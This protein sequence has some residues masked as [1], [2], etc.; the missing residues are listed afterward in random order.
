MPTSVYRT[1][2]Q[3]LTQMIQDVQASGSLITDFNIGSVARVLLEAEAAG[4]SY[5]S[6]VA[7]QL[8]I[9][10]YLDTA[11]GAALD[12]LAGNFQVTRLPSMLATGEVTI[13]RSQSSYGL[14]IPAGWATLS[15]IPE[16]S[17]ESVDVVTL[18]DAVFAPGQV[19]VSV[20]AQALA[21]GRSGNL[22]GGQPLLPTVPVQGVSSTGG[23]ATKDQWAGGVDAETDDALRYRIP[24][25][26][27]GRVKGTRVSVLG[28]VLS[29]PGVIGANV[30]QAGDTRGD[31]TTIPAGTFEVYYRG[32]DGLLS[33]VQSATENASVLNQN[34]DAFAS[35]DLGGPIMLSAT[36]DALGAGLTFPQRG[37]MRTIVALTVYVNPGTDYAIT[38]GDVFNAIMGYVNV[39]TVGERALLSRVINLLHQIPAVISV[40]LPVTDF[41]LSTDLVGTAADVVPLSDSYVNLVAS[42]LSIA[43]STLS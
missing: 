11:T 9:D 5:Q 36:F 1:V 22:A 34:G 4:L 16:P 18:D 19:S 33:A 37:A 23:F 31:G 40:G 17:V 25:V 8:N 6:M 20:P 14:S 27:Q 28:S 21:G 41:R 15:T 35:V 38:A 43:I 13:T 3:Y 7:D 32:S 26:V 39:R 12:D 30:L 24:L 29:V 42:D 10:G 2:T